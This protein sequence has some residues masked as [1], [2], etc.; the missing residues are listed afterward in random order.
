MTI[1]HMPE[2]I[3]M[4]RGREAKTEEVDWLN[5]YFGLTNGERKELLSILCNNRSKKTLA[6]AISKVQNIKLRNILDYYLPDYSLP[7]FEEY[8]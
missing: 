6:T 2:S 8:E 3:L 5:K 1:L 4:N 7:L